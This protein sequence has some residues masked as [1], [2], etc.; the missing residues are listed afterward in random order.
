[1]SNLPGCHLGRAAS[2]NEFNLVF[3]GLFKSHCVSMFYSNDLMDS[4]CIWDKLCL[5]WTQVLFVFGTSCVC[6]GDKLCL[7]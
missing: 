1:M 2:K 5:Y 6:I 7:Y 4:V 3:S